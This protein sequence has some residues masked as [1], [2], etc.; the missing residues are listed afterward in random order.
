IRIPLTV[1]FSLCPRSEAARHSAERRSLKALRA[2]FQ[3]PMYNGF[4]SPRRP[5][6]NL[7]LFIAIIVPI[8]F[9]GAS[10]ALLNNNMNARLAS[11]EGR[12]E[13]LTGKVTELIDHVTRIE[14]G[15]ERG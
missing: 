12:F 13:I 5:M 8:L 14:E 7:Q 10:I 15:L 4:D 2:S 3:V 11:L 1:T 6:S 9:N